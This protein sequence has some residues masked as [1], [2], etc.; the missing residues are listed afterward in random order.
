MAARLGPLRDHGVDSR[1]LERTRLLGRRRRPEHDDAGLPQRR[2]ID[3]AEG[4]QER[5]RALVEH[6]LEVLL[7]QVRRREQVDG[8]RAIGRGA[9]LVDLGAQLVRRDRRSSDRAER[10]GGG[11]RR[12]QR[13][14]CVV[15]HRR[16]DDREP[17]AEQLAERRVEKAHASTS[18]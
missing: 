4:E 3:D 5:G 13:R 11:D 18:L 7:A 14:P 1:L 17:D 10:S 8:E 6:H 9:H 2:R 12:G 16:L 15:R